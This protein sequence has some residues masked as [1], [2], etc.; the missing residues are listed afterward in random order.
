MIRMIY[1]IGLLLACA[2][3]QA[4]HET[5]FG[6]FSTFGAFGGPILEF[7]SINGQMTADVG[8]GGALILDGFFIGGYGMGTEFP[9]ITLEREI[10]GQLMDIDYNIRLGQGGLWLGYVHNA[11]KLIHVFSS[12]KIGWG[13]AE[14]KHDEFGLPSDRIFALTP[15][16]GVEVN[17]S[18][19]FKL[20]FTAGYRLVNGI[21]RLPTL[22]ND[23]FS[24]P[25][26]T[27]TF[28]FGGFGEYG[29]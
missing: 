27:L 5:L 17:I 21:N 2:P 3:L 18:S 19:F 28:R 22:G 20:G 10:D 1:L 13:K 25:V 23:D 4:Q 26:G 11:P 8:G 6:D 9:S 14:L 29:D 24:S 7:S 16:L 15:E 12:L